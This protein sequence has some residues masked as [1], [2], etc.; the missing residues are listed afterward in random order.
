MSKIVA[1]QADVDGKIMSF[2][3][4]RFAQQATSAVVGRI[5]DTMVL[6][7]VVE[8]KE[9]ADLDYFPL[10]V[11]YAEKLYAGGRIKGS[12]WVKREGRASDDAILKARLIDRS[13]RPLFPKN[14]R[15]EVQI[16]VTVLSV[17][18]ENDSDILAINAVSAALAISPIPW[19]GPVSAARIGLVN[20][21]E[22]EKTP[23]FLI[24]PT[25]AEMDYSELDLVVTHTEKKVLMIEAGANQV[26]EDEF[27]SA[28]DFSSQKKDLILNTI[29]DLVKEVGAE[30]KA[31]PEEV[32]DK[33]LVEQIDKK[34]KKEL[35]AMVKNKAT[36][37]N[38]G[39][40]LQVLAEEIVTSYEEKYELKE[41]IKILDKLFKKYVR[42]LV[43]KENT[44]A[45][46]R[47]L[48]DIRPINIE[49]GVLPRTHGSAMFQRGQT[50]ALTIT[51][52]GAPSLEQY[53]E[54]MEGEET[55]RYMHHYYMP[56]YSVGETG[57]FGFPSR[58]E[59][60]HGAL[61]ERALLP[62]IPNEDVF[63]Y[64][65]RVVSEVV[66]S[67]GSTSMAST[68]GSTLSLM[69]AGVPI[70]E[71]VAGIACGL[72][73]SEDQ[74]DFR[75]L[76]DI[77]GIEDFGGDM[78][79]KVA[80]TK[81][82]ITAVQLDVKI[83]GLTKEMIKQTLEQSKE[84]RL[85]ILEK[86]ISVMPE[87][88]KQLSKYAPKIKVVKIDTEKIGEVIGP[89]GKVIRQIMAQTNTTLDVSDDG[90]VS[91]AGVSS[92]DVEKAASWV[93]MLT[94]QIK[95]GEE[96]EGEVKRILPFG[97]FVEVIPGK[98]GMV[99]VSQMSTGFVSNPSDVV[100]IGQKVKVRVMEI[101]DQG[102]INLS[103]LFGEDANKPREPRG[104]NR[105]DF[106]RGGQRP[107]R[108]SGPRR[109]RF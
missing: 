12:R 8:G 3:V 64:A 66:S 80:G 79:F 102:R 60:G 108:P 92:E 44:R 21:K 49:V 43:L 88:R 17:D 10:T 75:I 25:F 28:I 9:K 89:G 4:G 65:I 73:T 19:Q 16:I 74:K 5:G 76:T 33:E 47:G 35:L 71:P 36:K 105:S 54:K 27:L 6:A 67:N 22:G 56:P 15:K 7:T 91:I 18:G 1:K 68:C 55:K 106:N 82:G 58:R 39:D 23:T 85:F 104:G 13:V 98:E 38:Q 45:D 34:Y 83:D 87:P 37:E 2:E 52:L 14:Y 11:E 20:P 72:M 30:K 63:P 101:D 78:D 93:T 48:K 95:A 32:V 107:F 26:S 86:M 62:V 41:I 40:D 99:H 24:N 46:G 94:R 61:A 90:S 42:E 59:I 81:K 57:R 96:F 77:I 31:V 97:A 51:T 109:P 69:D 84:A 29:K 100:S 103:M 53:L 50:Q 70:T